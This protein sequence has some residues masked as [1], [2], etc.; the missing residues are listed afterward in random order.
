MVLEQEWVINSQRGWLESRVRVS[1][2]AHFLLVNNLQESAVSI[3]N[4]FNGIRHCLTTF[5][6]A[7]GERFNDRADFLEYT[8]RLSESEKLL[9]FQGY[10]NASECIP[11]RSYL[12][13]LVGVAECGVVLGR[14][15]TP[16]NWVDLKFISIVGN[17]S[18]WLVRIYLRDLSSTRAVIRLVMISIT[19]PRPDLPCTLSPVPTTIL[20]RSRNKCI[21]PHARLMKKPM[22]RASSEWEPVA[23]QS[24][25]AKSRP[26]E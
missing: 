11:E 16:V 5:F 10:L 9:C 15:V 4:K 26:K 14:E 6:S 12:R 25:F 24:K 19:G 3:E 7:T 1:S 23:S 8:V 18:K 20:T 21:L 13:T 17:D 2:P 22:R